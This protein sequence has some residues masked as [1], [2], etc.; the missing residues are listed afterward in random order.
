LA[1]LE[2]PPWSLCKNSPRRD[3][4]LVSIPASSGNRPFTFKDALQGFLI[5]DDLPFASILDS[6]RIREVFRKHKSLFGGIHETTLVLWAFL[7]QVL[8]DGKKASCQSAVG[9]IIAFLIRAGEAPPTADTGDYCKARAKLSEFAIKQICIELA[10]D[11]ER[12]VDTK[13]L[14]KN[15]NVYLVDGLTFQMPDTPKNQAAYP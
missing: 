8:R 9:R 2:I 12:Q 3:F 11:A 5:H 14:W 10:T 7:G 15:R 6:E 4:I 1:I 13:Q